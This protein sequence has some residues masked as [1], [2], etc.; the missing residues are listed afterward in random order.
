LFPKVPDQHKPGHPLIPNGFGVFYVLFATV[1]LFILYFAGIIKNPTGVSAPISAPLILA[2]CILFGGFMGLLDDWIDLKWRYKAFMP[3]IAALPLIYYAQ[4]IG[5]R[6]TLFLPYIASFHLG[7][8]Y[9][10][11]IIPVIVMI[12]TNAVN[13]LGGLNGLETICPAIVIV[14]LMALSSSYLLMVGPL[15]FWL[16]LAYFNFQGKIFVG[17]SGSFAIGLTIASFAVISDLK[18]SLLIAILPYIFNSSLILLAIFFTRQKA[19][20]IFDGNKLCSEHRRSL[21]TLITYHRPLSEK[22]AVRIIALIVAV[23]T[24]LAV[25]SQLY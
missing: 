5:A 24:V 21:I 19:K 6:T 15:L 18:L 20:V 4:S 11:V 3:L 16:V 2:S 12:V 25:A 9:F 7:A 14:G 10:Y 1:Y 23:F 22:Q 17:N 8:I 13:M